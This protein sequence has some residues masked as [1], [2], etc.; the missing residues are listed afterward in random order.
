[1]AG[2]APSARK[3]PSDTAEVRRR[4]IVADIGVGRRTLPDQYGA[5]CVAIGQGAHEQRVDD[6]EDADGCARSEPEDENR[7]RGECR[8]APENAG[9]VAYVMEDFGI[10]GE[11]PAEPC[12]I[13]NRAQ[14]RRRHR[15]RSSASHS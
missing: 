6:A 7:K 9:A 5:F 13:V 1:M 4:H 11:L 8:T 15:S 3:N 10:G 2:S 12:R 14:N